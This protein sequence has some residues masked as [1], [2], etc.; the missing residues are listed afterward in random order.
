MNI[1]IFGATGGIG[2]ALAERLHAQKEALFLSARHE[3]RLASLAGQTGSSCR[4]ADTCDSLQVDRVFKE[5]QVKL[6][7]IDGVAYC[8][9]SLL[10]K[11]AHL[12]T[13]EEFREVLDVNLTGAFYVLRAAAKAMMS[14]GGS[15][16]FVSSAAAR[17]G[18]MNHEAIA[19]AKAG[20][21]G[22]ALSAAATYA[23]RGIRVNAVAP[24]MVETPLTESLL[25]NPAARSMSESLHA[26]KRIGKPEEVA[27]MI[28]WLLKPENSW[29]T[30]QVFG[31]DGGLATLK[32]RPESV[33]RQ[34][35]IR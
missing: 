26:L 6:S 33:S 16:V 8:V 7:Q 5:A 29:V 19:A 24:G 20:L 35:G 12:T 13:D 3:P 21:M 1:I 15:I 30:G 32:P 34:G 4:S 18:M 25:K 31:I 2:K 23:P 17:T 9:G 27:S 11:P 22:L 10:L 14:S 28:E